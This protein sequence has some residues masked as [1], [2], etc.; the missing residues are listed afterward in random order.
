M[1]DQITMVYAM[2]HRDAM[3]TLPL[4]VRQKC[5][6]VHQSYCVCLQMLL[7]SALYMAACYIYLAVVP[8]DYCIMH[9]GPD[10]NGVC[11]FTLYT[12]KCCHYQAVIGIKLHLFDRDDPPTPPMH[13]RP[14]VCAP[15]LRCMPSDA[16]ALGVV[17]GSVL[18]LLGCGPPHTPHSNS[19]LLANRIPQPSDCASCATR[20]R[21]CTVLLTSSF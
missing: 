5:I 3:L 18:H 19:P 14:H 8:P 13:V 2:L 10:C 21:P 17:P 1:L 7:P 9:I 6:H 15:K 16:V 4:H 12:C 20:V 11:H